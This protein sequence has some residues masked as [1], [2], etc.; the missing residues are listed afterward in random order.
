MFSFEKKLRVTLRD[1][2]MQEEEMILCG[3]QMIDLPHCEEKNCLENYSICL[4]P[5]YKTFDA[6]IIITKFLWT[7]YLGGGFGPKTFF[8]NF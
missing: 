8:R 2:V 4:L 3:L 6:T 1:F 5:T 7:K